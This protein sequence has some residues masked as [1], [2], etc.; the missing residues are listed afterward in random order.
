MLFRSVEPGSELNR[1]KRNAVGRA[2]FDLE[3]EYPDE[4]SRVLSEYGHSNNVDVIEIA[5]PLG[6]EC[7]KCHTVVTPVLPTVCPNC[8]FRDTS[9]CPNCGQE[10]P[11]LKYVRIAGELYQC[12]NCQAKVRIRFNSP[13]FDD[14]GQMI[15]PVVIVS[16]AE[17]EQ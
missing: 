2:Y 3:T 10:V 12:P 1:T 14:Q 7:E 16:L 11:R 4:M 17:D 9:P 15:E 13:L 6:E 5:G 8:K